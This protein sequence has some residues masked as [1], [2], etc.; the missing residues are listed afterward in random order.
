MLK[1]NFGISIDLDRVYRMMDK[2]DDKAIEKLNRLSYIKTKALFDDK[3]YVIF[4]DATTIYFESFTE[5][6]EEDDIRISLWTMA[7]NFLY[8]IHP[9]EP[10][11]TK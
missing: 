3:I 10:E 7:E 1:D 4:F 6:T 8:A 11:K 2:L 5:D 9:K